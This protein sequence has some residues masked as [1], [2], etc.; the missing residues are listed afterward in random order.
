MVEN[1]FDLILAEI[2]KLNARLPCSLQLSSPP[3][4]ERVNV[5]LDDMGRDIVDDRDYPGEDDD[6]VLLMMALVGQGLHLRV[7]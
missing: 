6:V 3:K 2:G 1:C 5:L 4:P 7:A